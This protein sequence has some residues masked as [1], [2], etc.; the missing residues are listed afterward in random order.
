MNEEVVATTMGIVDGIAQR[1]AVPAE[2]IL[3]AYGVYGVG[4]VGVVVVALA[5]LCISALL[6]YKENFFGGFVAVFS[7]FGLLL[8]FRDALIWLVDRQAYAILQVMDIIGG[9]L[10]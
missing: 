1:L 4:D 2:A 6:I 10:K 9:A 8:H 3:T 5:G 7:I